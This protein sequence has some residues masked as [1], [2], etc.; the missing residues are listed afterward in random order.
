MGVLRKKRT[1]N[2]APHRERFPV[3]LKPALG[4]KVDGDREAAFWTCAQDG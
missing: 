4:Q 2:H 3:G 1:G